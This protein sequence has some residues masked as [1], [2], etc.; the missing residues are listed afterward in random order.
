MPSKK[1]G[2]RR[3]TIVPSSTKKELRDGMIIES[4]K[5]SLRREIRFYYSTLESNS[6]V[7]EN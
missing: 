7:K 6:L 1:S 2:E 5:K 4:N 3:H